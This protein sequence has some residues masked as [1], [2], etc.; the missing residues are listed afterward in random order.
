MFSSDTVSSFHRWLN[1]GGVNKLPLRSFILIARMAEFH[2]FD[3]LNCVDFMGSSACWV[4]PSL[5]TT[6]T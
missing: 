1:R 4:I 6:S 3:F 5:S 2:C